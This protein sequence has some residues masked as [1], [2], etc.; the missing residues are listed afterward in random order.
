M[1]H[2]G[3][4]GNM[5]QYM[6]KRWSIKKALHYIYINEVI[7]VSLILL[8]F[9]GELLVE[10][11][12]R[13]SL[14]YWLCVTPVFLYCSWL[15][16]KT[17]EYSTGVKNKALI[18]YEMVFWGSAMTSVLLIFLL[19]H[20]DM[21]RPSGAALSIHIILAHTMVL[22]GV[23]LGV[24][25]YLVGSFLFGTAALSVIFGGQFGIDLVLAIPIV[26]LGFHLEKTLLFPTLTR[27]EEFIQEIEK[28]K[29]QQD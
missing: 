22:L 5:T 13:V 1:I 28:E 11:A 23:F 29:S 15:S 7:F 25:Y 3:E 17:K 27:K 4:G 12:E 14:F 2:S 9:I 20:A 16:E 10:F 26:W 19:W 8:V 6:N 21:I 18:R 24:H